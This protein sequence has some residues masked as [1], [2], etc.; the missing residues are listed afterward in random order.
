MHSWW[1][2][3]DAY[4]NKFPKWNL[5]GWSAT[6][7]RHGNLNFW[8]MQRGNVVI[9]CL[10]MAAWASTSD[11][12]ANKPREQQKTNKIW[13]RWAHS[14]LVG[15][16]MENVT[17]IQPSAAALPYLANECK[18]Q[19]IIFESNGIYLCLMKLYNLCVGSVSASPFSGAERF[20]FT[21]T[22]CSIWYYNIYKYSAGKSV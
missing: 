17:R 2:P 21:R 1:S 22:H 15:R 13:T 9:N 6:N 3:A 16:H 18:H 5:F 10:N 20:Q 19:L 12:P 7:R 4:E 8:L 11:A 14:A